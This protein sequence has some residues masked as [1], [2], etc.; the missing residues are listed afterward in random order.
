MTML[1]LL[2]STIAEPDEDI[3]FDV[4]IGGPGNRRIDDDSLSYGARLPLLLSLG[5]PGHPSAEQSVTIC[6][7][8]TVA[9][10]EAT[11]RELAAEVYQEL[12]WI[13]GIEPS[14]SSISQ[15]QSTFKDSA[16]AADRLSIIEG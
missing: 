10:L 5:S 1:S 11:A 13:F 12:L 9:A 7:R 8:L 16:T 6:K 14:T 15:W 3:V 2:A 4:T